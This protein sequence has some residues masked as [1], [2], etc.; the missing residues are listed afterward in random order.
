MMRLSVQQDKYGSNSTPDEQEAL[1]MRMSGGGSLMDA[2][3]RTGNMR[4]ARTLAKYQRGGVSDVKAEYYMEPLGQSAESFVNESAVSDTPENSLLAAI[5]QFGE[6]PNNQRI[7]EN[8]AAGLMAVAPHLANIKAYRNLPLPPE[9]VL[10]NAP[11]TK[12]PDM[13]ASRQAIIAQGRNMANQAEFDSPQQ[14]IA[15]R[16]AAMAGTQSQLSRLAGQEQQ[17]EQS[18]RE[19]NAQRQFQNEAMNA[20]RINQYRNEVAGRDLAK[21]RGVGAERSALSNK[22]LGYLGDLD[23]QRLDR[24]KMD[25]VREKYATTGVL[26]RLAQREMER[27]GKVPAWAM[28]MLLNENGQ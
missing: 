13:E 2:Y 12:A 18:W 15:R 25:L 7:L 1:R 5:Q 9:P 28:N 27:T 24:E 26:K 14:A 17:L 23:R 6:N 4:V 8:T 16:A 21:I 3:R 11:V 10:T 22:I 19:R 20:Q